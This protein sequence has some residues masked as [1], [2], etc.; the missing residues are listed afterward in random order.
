MRHMRILTVVCVFI[1]A[2]AFGQGPDD[3]VA[4]SWRRAQAALDTAT[5]TINQ[6]A[7]RVNDGRQEYIQRH[8]IYENVISYRSKDDLMKAVDEMRKAAGA[9][10]GGRH[11]GIYN[12]F[13]ESSYIRYYDKDGNV[14]VSEARGDYNLLQE[15]QQ[16]WEKESARVRERQDAL[17]RDFDKY[18]QESERATAARQAREARERAEAESRRQAMEELRRAQEDARRAEEER[19]RRE[20]TFRPSRPPGVLP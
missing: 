14:I 16:Y 1:P 13:D 18:T 4:Y 17:R 19:R 9:L 11:I 20:D 6:D 12:P 5:A 8:K 10:E 7:T 15:Q 3:A 2:L